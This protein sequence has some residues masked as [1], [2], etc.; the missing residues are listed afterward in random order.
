MSP[1]VPFVQTLRQWKRDIQTIARGFTRERPPPFMSRVGRAPTTQRSRRLIVERIVRETADA[2]TI[3][4]RDPKGDRIDYAPGQFFTLTVDIGGKTLRRNYSASRVATG[5]E[6]AITVK[7]VRGGAL[8]PHLVESLKVGDAVSVEGPSGHFV[9]RPNAST[10]RSLLLI[11]GGSGIT[12]LMAIAESVLLTEPRSKVT[13][14][15]GNR[16][17]EDVIFREALERLATEHAPRFVVKHALETP[18]E[19]WSGRVGKLDRSALAEMLSKVDSPSEVYV[20]GP[21]PMRSEARFVLEARG[22]ESHRI[23]EERYT[24]LEA[25]GTDGIV[26]AMNV[27]FGGTVFSATTKPNET[28]LDAGLRAKAPMPYSCA[29]GGCGACRM[30]LVSGEVVMEEPNCLSPGEKREG[31]VLTCVARA[32]SAC[33]LED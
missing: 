6:V 26:A 22:V 32:K 2:V 33:V 10:T 29:M 5:V 16:S 14:L 9:V 25:R 24:L 1:S 17:I 4:L 27:S 7:R 13:L 23:H 15:Y 18:P 28:L 3:V 8:S 19:R 30:K 31:Y 12:P 11:G 20:C 21:A